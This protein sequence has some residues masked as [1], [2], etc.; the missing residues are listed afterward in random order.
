VLVSSSAA[1]FWGQGGFV[2][3]FYTYTVGYQA[4]S[5]IS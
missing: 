2:L 4:L 3:N 1:F 5:H